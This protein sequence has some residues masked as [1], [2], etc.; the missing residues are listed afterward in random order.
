MTLAVFVLP[1][2]QEAH[3]G[4]LIKVVIAVLFIIG[5]VESILFVIA[6]L[7][8]AEQSATDILA[9]EMTIDKALKKQQK[10]QSVNT[11]TSPSKPLVFKKSIR[12]DNL[13]YVVLFSLKYTMKI[14][15][16]WID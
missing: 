9:L 2:Y 7:N 6:N 15:R 13:S 3:S 4:I 8:V 12:L 5:A 11:D 14:K 10:R 1:Q 16:R